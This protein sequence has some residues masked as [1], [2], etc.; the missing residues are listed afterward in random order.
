MR[1]DENWGGGK[2]RRMR[3]RMGDD[4]NGE[5]ESGRGGE[6]GRKGIGSVEG[7]RAETAQGNNKEANFRRS[8]T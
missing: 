1:E 3:M 6:C 4:E 2:W 7:R 8:I 5:V